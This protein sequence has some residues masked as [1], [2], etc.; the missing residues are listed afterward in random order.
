MKSHSSNKSTTTG[1]SP[2]LFLILLTFTYPGQVMAIDDI[3][4]TDLSGIQHS[5]KSFALDDQL[6]TE[7]EQQK[8]TAIQKAIN[9]KAL[10]SFEQY[11][12]V[13]V[14]RGH[15]SDLLVS[16]VK[17]NPGFKPYQDIE[18]RFSDLDQGTTKLLNLKRIGTEIS[19]K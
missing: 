4:D 1:F 19:F 7:F 3:C 2:Q 15:F 14:Y 17:Q 18:V 6:L 5:S 9:E 8:L 11:G 13:G 12:V 10:I 16:E